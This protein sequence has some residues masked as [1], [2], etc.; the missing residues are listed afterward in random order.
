MR[1]EIDMVNGRCPNYVLNGYVWKPKGDVQVVLHIVHGMTEHMGRYEEFATILNTHGIAVVGYDLRG[2]GRNE[3][4]HPAATFIPDKHTDDGWNTAIQDV[5]LQMRQVREMFPGSKY[6][7]MGFSLGSFLVRDMMRTMPISVDGVILAGT[8]FQPSVV[9]SIMHS[10]TKREA[11]RTPVGTMSKLT[12]K[13]AFETYNKRFAPTQTSM[14]WLCSDS[15]QLNAYMHDP[16]VNQEIATD[17]FHDMI[18]AMRRTCKSG[19][20]K[21]VMHKPPVL[22]ISGSND[23]VGGTKGVR[24]CS[25]FLTKEGY[26]LWTH[27]LHGARHDIFHETQSG[28]SILTAEYIARWITLR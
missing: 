1:T 18:G 12:K 5:K 15:E 14:D 7:L 26:Q 21:E 16:L 9:L 10:I 25:K 6:C 19:V 24:A 8:G 22:L 27:I 23:A 13:L 28:A 4:E 3:N 2:H 20:Y 17:L 11:A